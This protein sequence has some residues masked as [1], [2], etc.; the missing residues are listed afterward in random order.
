MKKQ[1]SR[2]EIALLKLQMTPLCHLRRCSSWLMSS[3]TSPRFVQYL[4]RDRRV[5]TRRSE[6]GSTSCQQRTVKL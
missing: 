4:Q 6:L 3:M 5:D 1:A 2:P